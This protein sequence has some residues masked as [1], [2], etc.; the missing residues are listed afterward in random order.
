MSP[1]EFEETERRLLAWGRECN[2]RSDELM[3]PKTSSISTMIDHVRTETRLR[4]GVRKKATSDPKK[5]AQ[6]KGLAEKDVTAKGSQTRSFVKPT[7]WI[8]SESVKVDRAVARCPAWMQQILWQSYMKCRPD[9]KAAQNLR[10]S[11]M[12]YRQRRIAAVEH[13]HDLLQ[14]S[15]R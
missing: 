5:I 4:R 6:A 1:D 13:V 15:K 12:V 10:I 14:E 7:V 11:K 2:E 3:L 9:R 8:Q